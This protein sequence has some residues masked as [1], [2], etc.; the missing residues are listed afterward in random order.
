MTLIITSCEEPKQNEDLIPSHESLPSTSLYLDIESLDFNDC[1]V[2]GYGVQTNN[3]EV[4]NMFKELLKK[5]TFQLTGQWPGNFHY[6]KFTYG[7]LFSGTVYKIKDNGEWN[8]VIYFGYDGNHLYILVGHY[9]Q[10]L[11]NTYRTTGDFDY[12]DFEKECKNIFLNAGDN[13]D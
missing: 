1:Y 11:G 2:S 12:S 9:I 3:T 7:N 13:Y 10:N 5:Y 4:L 6:E 8:H